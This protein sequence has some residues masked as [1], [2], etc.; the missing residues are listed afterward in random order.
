M[1][2][3]RSSGKQTN[4]IDLEIELSARSDEDIGAED[5]VLN[6]EVSGD[7]DIGTETSTGT[8]TISLVDSTMKQ[9]EPKSAGRSVPG[10]HDRD[11]GGGRR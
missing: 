9:V 8:F 5:L 3:S 1:L 10:D 7:S 11:G 6:L 2:E 4:D